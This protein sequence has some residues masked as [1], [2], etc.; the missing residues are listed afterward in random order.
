MD[1]GTRAPKIFR[2]S[3]RRMRHIRMRGKESILFWLFVAWLAVLIFIMLPYMV[4]NMS[5]PGWYGHTAVS[6]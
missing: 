5:E 6:R 3:R 4:Q 2:G 1:W